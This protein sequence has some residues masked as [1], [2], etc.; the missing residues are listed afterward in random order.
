MFDVSFPQPSTTIVA[1]SSA[2]A[3]PDAKS[4]DRLAHL[5]F[6]VERAEAARFTSRFQRI[7][8]AVRAAIVPSR[9]Q[10]SLAVAH[11]AR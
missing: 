9:A 5:G 11:L 4:I 3:R 7:T 8:L 1:L 2:V 10:A 6:A